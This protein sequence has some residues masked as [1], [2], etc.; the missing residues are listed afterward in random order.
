LDELIDP[1]SDL[2]DYDVF[3]QKYLEQKNL[4]DAVLVN[5][6]MHLPFDLRNTEAYFT[7]KISDIQAQLLHYQTYPD[8]RGF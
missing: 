1:Q 2:F 5:A 4:Y 7:D 3:Y 6:M 8:L